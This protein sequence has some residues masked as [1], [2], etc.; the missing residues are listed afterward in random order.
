[1]ARA[2]SRL[3]MALS[4]VWGCGCG[5]L[6]NTCG[7]VKEDG[8]AKV[9]GGMKMDLE[10]GKAAW[11]QAIHPAGLLSFVEGA[12]IAVL[13]TLDLPFSVAGDTLTLPMTVVTE[14]GE[15][16]VRG[17]MD[18][19]TLPPLPPTV[20]GSF[21]FKVHSGVPATEKTD[22]RHGIPPGWTSERMTFD[23]IHGGIE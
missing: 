9:Y 8:A 12:G 6:A 21:P 11:T 17:N 14:F 22:W 5:T 7:R 10:S 16:M 4:V 18:P 1:M 3:V 15:A 19:K 2:V 20:I 23:R 13:C